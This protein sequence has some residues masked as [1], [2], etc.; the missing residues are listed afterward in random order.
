MTSEERKAYLKR[1]WNKYYKKPEHVIESR[2]RA[3]KNY[4]IKKILAL[5]YSDDLTREKLNKLSPSELKMKYHELDY[6]ING[7]ND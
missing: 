2:I 6:K 1:Y 7:E 5:N 4:W 3:L